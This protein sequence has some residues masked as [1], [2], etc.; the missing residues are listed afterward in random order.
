MSPESGDIAVIESRAETHNTADKLRALV[1]EPLAG[2]LPATHRE[3]YQATI[4]LDYIDN[5]THPGGIHDY[6]VTI[7]EHQRRAQQKHAYGQI[8]GSLAVR[9]VMHGYGDYV[10]SS[11]SD[12]RHLHEL[13]DCIDDSVATHLSLDEMVDLNKNKALKPAAFLRFLDVRA[14]MQERFVGAHD[15]L[16]THEYRRPLGNGKNKIIYDGY[17][18]E[19][20][21]EKM[22]MY[23]KGRLQAVTVDESQPLI[24]LALRDQRLR[25]I[26]WSKVLG[27]RFYEYERYAE[28]ARRLLI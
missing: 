9:S 20:P 2:F 21:D 19:T 12:G 25:Y 14:V 23:M 6:L 1:D 22:A 24:G 13:K 5:P 15:P 8:Q 26:F 4:L 18:A 28:D 11:L 27:S 10:A 16:L 17:T 7:Y 3:K